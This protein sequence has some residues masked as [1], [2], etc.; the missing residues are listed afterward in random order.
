MYFRQANL[1]PSRPIVGLCFSVCCRLQCTVHGRLHGC[2]PADRCIHRCLSSCL[3]G[4][5]HWP[6]I[7]CLQFGCSVDTCV[8]EN[9]DG[10]HREMMLAWTVLS[11]WTLALE[12]LEVIKA[13][14]NYKSM[15]IVS[16]DTHFLLANMR[17]SFWLPQCLGTLANSGSF[18]SNFLL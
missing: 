8:M 2:C 12:P 6:A 16:K 17:K 3:F 9:P 15:Q 14:F 1:L 11:D 4:C 7:C 5:I 18:F 10:A 13:L